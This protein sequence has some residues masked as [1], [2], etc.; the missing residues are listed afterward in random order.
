MKNK[1]HIYR[2]LF[3][4]TF[5]LSAFTFG[6]GFVIIPLMKKKF[7]DDLQWIK[8]DEMLNLAA[9]AQSSPGAV[10]V[11]AAI[12][13]GYRV[14]GILGAL[15]TILGTI[16]PPIITLT[17]ISFF[18]AAFR[19]NIVVNSVLKGMQAGIAAV[20]ADVALN[21]GDNVLKEKDIVFAIIMVGAFVATF[22]L[23]INVIYIILVCGFIGA[24]KM[25]LQIRKIQKEGDSQ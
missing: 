10:A 9:I 3:T 19:D 2:K 11:N 21:L 1:K 5:Y 17:I 8:E 22:F 14:A 25:L 20:I 7:V 15:V 18:Y 12:L 4:S 13:L 16:L 23:G 6:G 24:A